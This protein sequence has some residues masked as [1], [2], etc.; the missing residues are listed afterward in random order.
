MRGLLVSFVTLVAA[1]SGGASSK[2][3]A[4]AEKTRASRCEA[5]VAEAGK[6]AAMVM[7]LMAGAL[8][9]PADARDAAA[10]A[11][12]G[13]SGE[14]LAL[15]EKC[16]AWPERTVDCLDDTAFRL[17]HR[18]ECDE[19]VAVAMG[20]TIPIEEVAA[21]P[22][23]AW[24]YDL[25]AKPAPLLLRDDGWLL[26]RTVEYDENYDST[27]RL[28]AVRGGEKLW[29]LE[30]DT[31][32]QLLDLGARGIAVVAQGSL[33][34]LDPT[35]GEVKETHRPT[36]EGVPDFDAEWDSQPYIVLVAADGDTLWVADTDA[37]FYR[38]T[39]D[40]ARFD[41][42][43]PEESLD[44]GARLSV[45][46]EHRW[47]WEDYDVRILDAKWSV[48]ASMRAHDIMGEVEPDADGATLVVD[49]EVVRLNV[50][51]C[52]GPGTMDV[53]NWPHPGDFVIEDECEHCR[54]PPEGCIAW[55]FPLSEVSNAP[56][57]HL[58][59]G[60]IVVSNGE[61]TVALRDGAELWTAGTGA[62]GPAAVSDAVYVFSVEENRSRLWSIEPETGKPTWAVELPGDDGMLYNTDDITVKAAGP[63][64][65]AGYQTRLIG[66]KR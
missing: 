55:S 61:K 13:M 5:I 20:Q 63:W 64:V 62:A 52:S 58:R 32:E 37:R 54:R 28:T 44:S 38:V 22:E 6:E 59:G 57:G 24:T 15:K 46:G 12:L 14:L 8:G 45:F 4:K 34:I 48:R 25:P 29:E 49:G 23:P 26:A 18:D 16:L 11:R 39:K 35:T 56:V 41:G 2:S 43:L 17:L 65:V 19:A 9:D 3:S 36:G 50:A 66:L 21:G 7:G 31:T 51:R 60:G 40:G 1:C 47:L 27:E 42:L 30:K 53:S 10:E 33:E